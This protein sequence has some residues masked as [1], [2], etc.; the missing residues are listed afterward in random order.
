MTQGRSAGQGGA[1]TPTTPPS[2]TPTLQ[3]PF[4][5]SSL[6][7]S[8][9]SIMRRASD[10]T[11]ILVR[12]FDVIMFS[13][14]RSILSRFFTKARPNLVKGRQTAARRGSTVVVRCVHEYVC[15]CVCVYVCMW[16][17]VG[18]WVG[19]VCVFVCLDVCLCVC[20]FVWAAVFSCNRVGKRSPTI[21]DLPV[22]QRGCP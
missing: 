6:R 11:P 13:V 9:S 10:D 14:S 20:V 19:C 8:R 17:C 7:Q 18:G 4:T 1:H 2:S 15:T 16:V 21:G 5:C 12:M 3:R 22:H